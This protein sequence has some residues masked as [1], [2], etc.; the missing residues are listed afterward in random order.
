MLTLLHTSD[1]HLGRRLYG[2]PRYEEFARFLA[3]QVEMIDRH[4]VDVLLIAG[5]IFDTTSPSNQ[6]Q[7]LYYDFLYKVNQTDCRHVVIVGGN[8]DSPSFLDAP[9]ALLKGFNIHVIGSIS[10][11]L[12]DEILIL[13]D[14]Q[15]TPEM[16]II[17]VPYLRDRD[18]RTVASGERLD[19]KENK[20]IQGIR[21]HYQA[22]TELAIVRQRA[23][24]QQTGK[25]IPL[26]GTGHLFAAGGKTIEDDGVRELYVGSLAHVSADIFDRHLDYVALG[27]LHVPQNV[28]GQAHIRYSGSPI[29]MGFGEA[30]QQKQV[31][32]VRF[33]VEQKLAEQPVFPLISKL[34]SSLVAVHSSSHR[35]PLLDKVKKANP[36]RHQDTCDFTLLLDDEL[37]KTATTTPRSTALDSIDLT[38]PYNLVLLSDTIL[39]Q[40]LAVPTFQP[41]LS[42]KGDWQ[43]IQAT[44]EP[45]KKSNQSFWLEV[46]YDSD[47]VMGDLRERLD[48]LIKDSQLEV[49]RLKNLQIKNHTLQAQ[50]SNETLEELDEQQVF[51]RCLMAHN[52]SDAQK[53]VMWARYYDVLESLRENNS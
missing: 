26:I 40:S 31:H 35:H 30:S 37:G 16:I 11:Q 13:T 8:H 24:E 33:A 41:L 6:A 38:E 29:A 53:P 25:K 22:V 28:G 21:S 32:L 19:D 12:D 15:G 2:K 52:V 50:S 23:L 18:V 43:T 4:Q 45:L 20:L 3:W 46:I 7:S 44:L 5:D 10:D 34:S 36:T 49:I 27:H 47:T 51:E 14:A 17:A 48:A 39:L 9:K 42:V 1:W